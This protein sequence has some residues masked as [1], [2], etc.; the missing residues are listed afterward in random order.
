MVGQECHDTV[1]Y[2]VVSGQHGQRK[3]FT[4]IPDIQPSAHKKIVYEDDDILVVNNKGY[5][6]LSVG[7]DS[8]KEGNSLFHPARISQAQDQRNKIFIVHRLRPAY[9]RPDDVRQEHPSQGNH[10]A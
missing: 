1:R 5:G 2:R 7:T 9:L 3:H 6:L 10:A 8:I 4:R